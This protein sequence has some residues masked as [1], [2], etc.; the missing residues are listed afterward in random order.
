MRWTLPFFLLLF[1]T[2]LSAQPRHLIDSLLAIEGNAEGLDRIEIS[3]QLTRHYK[4]IPNKMDSIEYFA[5]QTIDL[6][7]AIGHTEGEETGNYFLGSVYWFR[8]ENF[9][10]SLAAFQKAKDIAIDNQHTE[11]LYKTENAIGVVQMLM[12][13]YEQSLQ[14]L[15]QAIVGAEVQKDY[16]TMG[17]ISSNMGIIYTHINGPHKAIAADLAALQYI[18]MDSTDKKM[19]T[20]VNTSL[21]LIELYIEV[22]SLEVAEKM[23]ND[24]RPAVKKLDYHRATGRLAVGEMNLLKKLNQQKELC[25]LA[26][27][28]VQQF[29]LENGYDKNIYSNALQYKGLCLA[30]DGKRKEATKIVDKI[31]N[32]A[33]GTYQDHQS[34]IFLAVYNIY[35][36]LGDYQNALKFHLKYKETSDSLLNESKNKRILELQALYDLE[37]KEKEIEQ[38]ENDKLTLKQRNAWLLAALMLLLL[39]GGVFYFIVQRNRQREYAKINQIEQKM[40]SLQMNP[41]FIFNAISSIQNYLFDQGDTKTAIRHLSTFA[42]LMRQM[43]ENSQEKFISLEAEIDF[44]RSYLNLQKL[45]FDDKFDFD[46]K[47]SPNINAQELSI[48]PLLTQPFVENAIEHGKI[49]QVKNGQ[50][51]VLIEED[52]TGIVIKILDNGVGLHSSKKE[53]RPTT[54]VLK[55]KSMSIAIIRERLRLLSKLMNKNFALKIEENPL[56]DGTMVELKLPLVFVK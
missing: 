34:K 53:Q 46:I 23:I 25:E 29:A 15:Q 18:A 45:R 44:L 47:I 10:K 22:D 7:K 27:E 52:N 4:M 54:L 56:N 26:D 6:S 51:N 2:A 28:M 50:L 39:M 19:V 31:L 17:M 3:I 48:P 16:M 9:P 33:D 14:S 11:N 1:V 49:Y 21:N 13:N 41:H 5:Q 35:E 43:L 8:D 40:L 36:A 55:K 37:K 12:G 20:Y 24:L 32:L 30:N 42:S 38:S